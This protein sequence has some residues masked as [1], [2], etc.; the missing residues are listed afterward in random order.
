M[1][2]LV[3][4]W[5]NGFNLYNVGFT[6]GIM[7][8]VA[9]VVLATFGMG[10]SRVLILSETS[11]WALDLSAW[12]VILGFALI[13]FWNRDITWSAIKQ[14]FQHGGKSPA[15]FWLENPQGVVI[16]NMAFLGATGMGL[17]LVFG[18]VVN[19][20]I[21]AA[22]F[23]MIGFGAFGKHPMNSWAPIVGSALMAL[24]LGKSLGSSGIM[25]VVLFT[26]CLAP[27]TLHFGIGWGLVAGALHV[28]LAPALG[29]V[30]GGLN[31]Y[32]NGY[33]AGV[34][35]TFLYVTAHSVRKD[36]KLNKK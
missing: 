6:T 9:Q 25:S 17:T 22:V 14:L 8:M 7:G 13:A 3:Y 32:N 29:D 4:P 20:P 10:S 2:K 12:I 27:I 35:A 5:H 24:V 33:T 15:D 26:S 18:G 34:V 1:T 16:L 19:G 36:L 11:H 23:S 21:L 28:L 30:H 31:L